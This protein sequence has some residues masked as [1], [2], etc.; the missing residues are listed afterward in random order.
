MLSP[1]VLGLA[2]FLPSYWFIKANNEIIKLVDFSFNSIQPI[3]IDMLIVLIFA[4]LV[5]IATQII[6]RLRLKK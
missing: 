1:F 3:L 6:T 2:K 4:L 5:Y